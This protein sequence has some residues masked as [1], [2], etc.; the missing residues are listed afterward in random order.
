MSQLLVTLILISFCLIGHAAELDLTTTAEVVVNPLPKVDDQWRFSMGASAWMPASNTSSFGTNNDYI[1]STQSTVI[2][3]LQGNGGFAMV[4][5]EA[6][7]ENW[8]IM[9]DLVY[10]QQNDGTTTT[11]YVTKRSSTYFG[12][13]AYTDQT[14]FTAVATY[15]VVNAPSLYLDAL[16]GARYI[17]STTS[18]NVSAVQTVTSAGKTRTKISSSNVSNTDVSTDLVIGLKGRYRIEDTAWY[19]PFYLDAG[20]GLG[21]QNITWQALAGVGYA[22]TWG[23]I[24]LSY[25][26]MY[27][28]LSGSSDGLTK[29]SNYGPQLGVNVNF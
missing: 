4:S 11:K 9:A 12:T 10:W 14:L 13:S 29:Y 26:A 19:I 2:D 17:S 21:P 1:S 20:S 28:D 15:T 7:K 18:V 16:L 27:F 25:R 8:G 24:S 22:F 23:D 6:H 3:T 5:A